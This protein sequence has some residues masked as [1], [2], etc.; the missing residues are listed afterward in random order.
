MRQW[1]R[2]RSQLL[3]RIAGATSSR[4][5]ARGAHVHSQ[6]PSEDLITAQREQLIRIG[7][8]LNVEQVHV[9]LIKF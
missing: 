3:P 1:I 2:R 5:V 9:V 8:W 4:I 6:P 7:K